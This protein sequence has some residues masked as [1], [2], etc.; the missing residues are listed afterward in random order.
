MK[1][2]PLGNATP[3]IGKFIVSHQLHILHF[4]QTLWY[5]YSISG[6]AL[7]AVI[8][9]LP[10]CQLGGKLLTCKSLGSLVGKRE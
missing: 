3:L 2:L 8:L 4:M 9:V 10:R 1:Y 7:Y 5:F 6:A